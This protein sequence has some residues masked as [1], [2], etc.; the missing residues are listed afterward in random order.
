MDQS[1]V[2]V[3]AFLIEEKSS[4]H[5]CP[6]KLWWTFSSHTVNIHTWASRWLC[7]PSQPYLRGLAAFPFFSWGWGCYPW[8][9]HSLRESEAFYFF[10]IGKSRW[11][12][13][14]FRYRLQ[15]TT[16]TL[17]WYA[18]KTAIIF[19]SVVTAPGL[20]IGL[21]CRIKRLNWEE[22]RWGAQLW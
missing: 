20:D 18:L 8:Y 1:Q 2:L 4:G 11:G 6:R 12:L 14:M 7:H 10:D 22:R 9:I 5:K 21:S 19:S 13:K 16:L 15:Y 17:I 3:E